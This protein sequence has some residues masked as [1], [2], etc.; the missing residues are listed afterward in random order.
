MGVF[1]DL[2][3]GLG[4]AFKSIGSMPSQIMSTAEILVIGLVVVIGGVLIMGAWSVSSGRTNVN[5]I[6]SVVRAVR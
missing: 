6:A 3:S 4:N 5:D 1:G 2:G